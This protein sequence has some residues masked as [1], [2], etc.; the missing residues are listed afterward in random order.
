MLYERTDHLEDE[1][2]ADEDPAGVPVMR[3]MPDGRMRAT[4]AQPS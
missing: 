1:E 4:Q 2:E 3:R